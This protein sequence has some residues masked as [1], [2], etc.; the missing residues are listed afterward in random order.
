MQP[1]VLAL[2]V[3]VVTFTLSAKLPEILHRKILPDQVV[4][5][6]L[7]SLPEAGGPPQ[8]QEA[9]PARVETKVPE[10]VVKPEA[11]VK[12]PVEPKAEPAPAPAQPVK[13][14]SLKP[15]K[16]KVMKTDPKK[17]AEEEARRK[18][19]L[20]RQKDLAQAQQ[21]EKR[22]KEAAE[23]ARAALAEMIQRKGAQQASASPARSSSGSG[24]V[25]SLAEQIF[26]AAIYDRVKQFWILPEMR[27]WDPSLET[28]V[29]VT[30][31][32]N[33]SIAGTV[34]EKKS[35]DPFY[36]QYVM[37]TVEKAAPLPAIPKMLKMS[38]VEVGLVFKP[39]DLSTM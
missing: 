6:N 15:L 5:V 31:R 26:Y 22:A 34:I 1:V 33:G 17:L 4:T 21:E 28:R 18:R 24:Q 9:P 14:V 27:K 8:Q 13:P 37:K 19:E 39:G 7:V 30:I 11:A 36:D 35:G 10:P 29:V 38:S 3:H 25:N 16:R 32:A 2:V 12:I 20:E 23:D